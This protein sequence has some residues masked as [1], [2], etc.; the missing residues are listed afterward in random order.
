[1]I[2]IIGFVVFFGNKNKFWYLEFEF[3]GECRE[4]IVVGFDFG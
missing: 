1:M 3:D 4:V 2:E